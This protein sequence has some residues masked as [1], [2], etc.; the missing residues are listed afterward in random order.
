MLIYIQLTPFIADT[1]GTSCQ[2]PHQR[3]SVIAGVYFS[4]TSVICFFL[5]FSCCPFYRGVRYSEVSARRELTV[6]AF[7]CC[8][9]LHQLEWAISGRELIRIN[10]CIAFQCHLRSQNTVWQIASAMGLKVKNWLTNSHFILREESY[11]FFKEKKSIERFKNYQLICL[12][13]PNCLQN[14]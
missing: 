2:C 10:F 14:H 11:F 3:E 4:Q 5:G 1:V 7:F 12:S 8:S 6:F 13:R 9:A